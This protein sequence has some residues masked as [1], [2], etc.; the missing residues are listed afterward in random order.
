VPQ[1]TES[2]LLGEDL[3]QH[4]RHAHHL[5]FLGVILVVVPLFG[6]EEH[7]SIDLALSLLCSPTIIYHLG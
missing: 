1:G 6:E 5:L 3:L 2:R 4:P 7:P